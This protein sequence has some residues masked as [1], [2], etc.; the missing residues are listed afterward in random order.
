MK[1]SE[2]PKKR[3]WNERLGAPTP[4]LRDAVQAASSLDSADSAAWPRGGAA[5]AAHSA[6]GRGG[7]GR[8]AM[9]APLPRHE[10]PPKPPASAVPGQASALRKDRFRKQHTAGQAGAVAQAGRGAS[11]WSGLSKLGSRHEAELGLDEA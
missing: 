1:Q 4:S 6:A 5:G 10:A 3:R 2:Q 9:A 8:A 7:Y 11:K